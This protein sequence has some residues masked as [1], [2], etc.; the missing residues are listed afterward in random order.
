MKLAKLSL[1]AIAV[2][3]LSC[4]AFAADTLA[5]AFKEGKVSGTLQAY[6]F[7]K[8]ATVGNK[9]STKVYG[10]VQ[11]NTRHSTSIFDLGAKL[12]YV[13]GD[14]MGFTAGLSFQGNS[15]PFADDVAKTIY[16]G[17]MYGTGAQL[18]QAYLQ[19]ANSGAF[20]KAGR[21]FI[22]TPLV[23][24]SGSRITKESFEGYV[25]GYTGLPNTVIAAG[26]VTKYQTRTDGN[27]NIG[28]FGDVG[29]GAW[30]VFATNKSIKGL[31]LT[32]AYAKVK[33]ITPNNNLKVWYA[34]AKY[35]ASLSSST[36]VRVGA[37]YYDSSTDATKNLKS[38]DGDVYSLMLGANIN[39]LDGQIAYGQVSSSSNT[40]FGLG[41]GTGDLYNNTVGAM[42]FN[43]T[44]AGIKN[45][46]IKV[47]YDLSK[48]GVAGAKIAVGYN[49]FSGATN[50]A[51][52][53]YTVT[54]ATASYAF[55][56]SL[57]GLKT[58]AKYESK[59]VSGGN[60]DPRF[61]LYVTY[62]F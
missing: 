56:G 3:S 43:D 38:L 31:A 15:A 51:E 32:A 58:V 44:T 22:S 47:G 14:F 29:T 37:N 11:K 25:A 9:A 2:V 10:N 16:N 30:T 23:A 28:N 39:G 6:Y 18:S 1:A 33:D 4:S 55:A 41:N 46:S 34:N 62:S 48:V 20:I 12:N 52:A 7:A 45:L 53:D 40:T 60:T 17:D 61:R 59:N 57:K 5:G 36:K 13:T 24:G 54:G 21:Q 35:V 42:Y 26:Y 50:N 27:G 19:Y 49:K 8:T